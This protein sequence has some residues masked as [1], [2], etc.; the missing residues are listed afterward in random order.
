MYLKRYHDVE[1]S[2]SGVWPI[3]KRL[4]ASQ[5]YKRTNE[6]TLRKAACRRPGPNRRQVCRAAGHRGPASVGR[7][8]KHYQFTAIDDCTRL[9]VL[10]IYPRGPTSTRAVISRRCE[11]LRMEGI[12]CK[13]LDTALGKDGAA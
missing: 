11:E 7:R 12:A 9:R 2:R 13:R 3:L 5:R 6:A 1:V 8:T 4:P 10:R